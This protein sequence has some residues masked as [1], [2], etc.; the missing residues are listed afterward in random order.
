MVCR[1]A[2]DVRVQVQVSSRE[3]NRILADKAG[4]PGVVVPRPTVTPTAGL[5]NI[6]G[7]SDAGSNY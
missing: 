5:T 2:T 7:G 6:E 3:P 4:E 1:T